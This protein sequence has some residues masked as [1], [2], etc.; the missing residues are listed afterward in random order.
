MSTSVKH[1]LGLSFAAIGQLALLGIPRVIAHDLQ[2]VDPHGTINRLLVF[3]PLLIWIGVVIG[4]KVEKPF[5][6]LLM[7]G[8]CY[9]VG[10]AIT[11]QLLWGFAFESPPMLGGNLQHLSP[12]MSNIITRTFAFMSSVLTG[13]AIGIVLGLIGKFI[14]A[15]RRMMRIK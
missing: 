9:G 10:L 1:P 5:I 15:A 12:T 14:Y 3:L 4:K 11:H 7:I 8:I 6:A 13:T 2:W